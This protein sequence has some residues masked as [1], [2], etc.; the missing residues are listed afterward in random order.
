MTT[1]TIKRELKISGEGPQL[2][3]FIEEFDKTLPPNW[4][5]LERQIDGSSADTHVYMKSD[6][7]KEG[8]KIV[9]FRESYQIYVQN[10]IPMSFSESLR[11]DK[12]WNRVIEQLYTEV[13]E[14]VAKRT[15]VKIA[16]DS[17][18]VLL[19]NFLSEETAQKLETFSGASYGTTHPCD[20]ERWYT[21]LFASHKEGADEKLTPD[22]LRKWFR[23]Q[24]KWDEDQIEKMASK[25]E[26]ALFMLDKYDRYSN[27]LQFWAQ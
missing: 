26:N 12:D 9:L 19:T 5:K 7:G 2:A 27:G 13:F 21:F 1:L 8:L 10:L 23:A 14:P 16:L 17:A 6:Y 15:N 25:Y 22:I 24:N 20:Q 3:A 4:T 11:K 18:K